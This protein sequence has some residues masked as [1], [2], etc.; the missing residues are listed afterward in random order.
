ME[1]SDYINSSY[2]DVSSVVYLFNMHDHFNPCCL[3]VL[4]KE[5]FHRHTRSVTGYNR[6]LLEDDLGATREYNCNANF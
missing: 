4:D 3:G 1:N 2:I 5:C 6:G